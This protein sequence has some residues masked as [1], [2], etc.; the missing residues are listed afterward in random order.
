MVLTIDIADIIF[1]T[2]ALLPSVQF[3]MM[4]TMINDDHDDDGNS[5][6]RVQV[7]FSGTLHNQQIKL[8]G[9]PTCR[10]GQ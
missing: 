5:N 7:F 6:E 1:I 2:L 4:A 3:I 9:H 8:K 10:R